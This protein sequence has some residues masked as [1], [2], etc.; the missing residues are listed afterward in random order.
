VAV[1]VRN[2]RS[3][4][5]HIYV[6]ETNGSQDMINQYSYWQQDSQF[7]RTAQVVVGTSGPTLVAVVTDYAQQ[8][9]YYIEGGLC[10][11]TC[12]DYSEICNG[13][14]AFVPFHLS[15]ALLA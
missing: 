2:H 10:Q 8:L 11:Y 6:Y 4:E 13:Q 15:P 12:T 7:N 14:C 9:D 1:V 5:E 3:A